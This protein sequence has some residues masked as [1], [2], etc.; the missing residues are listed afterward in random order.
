[1]TTGIDINNAEN[2][3]FFIVYLL[4]QYYLPTVKDLLDIWTRNLRHNIGFIPLYSHH[5]LLI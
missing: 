4:V 3:F 2:N 5:L 1:M